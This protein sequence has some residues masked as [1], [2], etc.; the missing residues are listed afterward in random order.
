MV[1]QRVDLIVAGD[2]PAVRAAKEATAT[3]PIVMPSV[4]DAVGSGLVASL[5]RPGGNVTG[6][7][8]MGSELVGKRL[9]LLKEVAPTI[10]RVAVLWHPGA[11]GEGMVKQTRVETEVAAGALGLDLQWVPTRKPDDFPGAFASA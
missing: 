1:R 9:Q 3:I 8:F 5:A 10:S 6:L 7:S 11:H 4:A 2:T